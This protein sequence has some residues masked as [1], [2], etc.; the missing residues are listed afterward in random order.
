LNDERKE[1]TQNQISAHTVD[2]D[3]Y[4]ARDFGDVRPEMQHG[5]ARLLIKNG[6]PPVN[7]CVSGSTNSFGHRVM[8]CDEADKRRRPFPGSFGGRIYCIAGG[9]AAHTVL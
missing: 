4:H 3:D 6:L 5:N 1:C 8:A 9:P 2:S 7:R